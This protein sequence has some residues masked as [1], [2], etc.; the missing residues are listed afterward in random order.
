MYRVSMIYN[1]LHSISDQRDFNTCHSGSM[2]L[3]LY[4]IDIKLII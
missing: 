1:I 4:M 3:I 2:L